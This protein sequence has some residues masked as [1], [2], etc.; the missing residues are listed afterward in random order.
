MNTKVIIIGPFGADK[1]SLAN[2]LCG[3]NEFVEATNI[4]SGMTE[5]IIKKLTWK[6]SE[7]GVHFIYIPEIADF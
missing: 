4:E 7:S 3:K 6:N 1:S 2:S 5:A